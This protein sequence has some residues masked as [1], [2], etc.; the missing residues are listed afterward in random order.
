MLFDHIS[1][2]RVDGTLVHQSTFGRNVTKVWL[3]HCTR[4][5][6]DRARVNHSAR[7]GSKPP[8]DWARRSREQISSLDRQPIPEGRRAVRKKEIEF[9]LQRALNFKDVATHKVRDMVFRTRATLEEQ[10]V[11][12]LIRP[13]TSSICRRQ[14][15]PK[16]RRT[17]SNDCDSRI[18][19]LK[20]HETV[21]HISC[22]NY[23]I[24][25]VCPKKWKN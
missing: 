19:T 15:P 6:A 23:E 1:R 11:V 13:I 20:L 7:E 18:W 3:H 14:K 5:G 8:A 10:D 12:S 24:E 2:T 16:L 17:W 21:G 9:R 22:Q 4:R 25:F